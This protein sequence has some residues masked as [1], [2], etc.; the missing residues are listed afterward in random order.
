MPRIVLTTWGSYGDLF[1]A[2]G[3]ALALKARGHVPVV[4]TCEFYR[5]IVEPL[6]IGFHPV[7]PDVD[8]NDSALIA[9]LMD[10]NRGSDVLLGELLAPAIRASFAAISAA[11]RGADLLV[12]HPATFA[13]PFVA[14]AQGIRWVASVLAPLS[15]F[16]RHDFPALSPMPWTTH[17]NAFGPGICGAVLAIARFMTRGMMRPVVELREELG[18]ADRGSP[19]FEGQFSPLGTLA[20]FPGVLAEPQPDWPPQVCRAGFVSY[21][22]PD[23]MPPELLAFL[24]AGAPPVAFTLGTSAVGAPGRFFTEAAAACAEAGCRGVLLVGRNP[25]N[26]PKGPLP[27]GVIAVDYA[28]HQ[29]L[30]PRAAAV[31]HQ[32][33]MGTTSQALRSGKPQL[34]VPH[35]HDQPDN[36]QRVNRLGVSCV[37]QPRRFRSSRVA[38][39]LRDLLGQAQYR[40]RAE[41][42]GRA[43]REEDG[44][45]AACD[46]IED[47]LRT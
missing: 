45:A 22:G 3:L 43:V 26:H 8:P 4:A 15:F 36:A 12:S 41:A 5:S 35:A 20:L 23:P 14:Q 39:H 18:L 33:G 17:L 2:V 29:Q 27:Q 31:V 11:A 46:A 32:G 24:E 25:E 9:R 19:L 1:P 44:A 30:F 28:P 34:I 16:S 7:P 37:C 21:N 42:V 13:T 38:A 10:P 40:M 47:A 6:G